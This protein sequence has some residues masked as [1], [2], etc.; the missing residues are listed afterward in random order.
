M[1][2]SPHASSATANTTQPSSSATALSVSPKA[3]P[4]RGSPKFASLRTAHLSTPPLAAAK[5]TRLIRAVATPCY[6]MGWTRVIAYNAVLRSISIFGRSATERKKTSEEGA[7]ILP[8]AFRA[9]VGATPRR[10]TSI[11]ALSVLGDCN[12]PKACVAQTR[13]SALLGVSWLAPADRSSVGRRASRAT[14]QAGKDATFR[15]RSSQ[16]QC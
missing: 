11:R 8:K 3:A 5:R 6:C 10:Y 12:L 9:D 14:W 15:A 2:A 7:A 16:T 13:R 4:A 1:P